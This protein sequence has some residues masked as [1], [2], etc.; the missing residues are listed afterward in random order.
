MSKKALGK[1]IGALF[2]DIEKNI[3]ERSIIQIPIEKI[4]PNPYQP[5]KYF[6]EES[7]KELSDS[8]K[9]KGIIQP[10]IAEKSE[11]GK[12]IIISGERRVRAA[13]LAGLK[14]VPT[15]LGIYSILEKLENALIENI[16]RENLSPL[17][18]AEGYKQL[19][20]SFKLNQE[21]I[22]K[23]VGKNRSTIANAIR[24]LKLPKKI[25][26]DL[27]K[28]K[29]TTGHARAI[30]SL[31][32]PIDQDYL[33]KEI[34]MRD[35]SVRETEKYATEINKGNK[36]FIKKGDKA[37]VKKKKEP[38][39]EEIENSLIELLGTK[40]EIKGAMEKGR[41]EISYFSMSDLERIIDI[42]SP[43]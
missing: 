19:I 21:E 43:Q 42:I 7:L 26:E 40:V 9:Q 27:S 20:E 39:F 22:A 2:K 13:K 38:G 31:V 24:L 12:Y 8:I 11:D 14:T 41:I 34:I 16:Q 30:L 15:I 10:I 3:D 36:S 18:E 28:G 4:K 6:P 17:E 5:R 1:G 33:H 23:R 32:N 37:G 35:L 25:K 29:I